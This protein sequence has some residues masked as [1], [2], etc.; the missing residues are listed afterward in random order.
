VS[1]VIA[2]MPQTGLVPSQCPQDG[3]GQASNSHV[4]VVVR[5]PLVEDNPKAPVLEQDVPRAELLA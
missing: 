1:T 5:S 2:E 3:V 4:E